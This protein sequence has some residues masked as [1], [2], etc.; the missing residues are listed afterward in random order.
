MKSR[1]FLLWI[2]LVDFAL[3]TLWV[4]WQVGYL[5]IW[6]AALSS[7]GSVQVLFDLA[8]SAGL[9]C[10]WIVADARQRG[11]VA[12]PWILATLVLGSLSLLAYLLVRESSAVAPRP[13]TA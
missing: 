6:Q 4:M 11:V 7:P 8:I 3:F 1:K 5:G 10:V 12:W 2:V 13:E 9:V